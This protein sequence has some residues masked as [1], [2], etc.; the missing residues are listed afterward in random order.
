MNW[1]NPFQT[2]NTNQIGRIGI[3]HSATDVGS[4]RIFENHWRNVGWR[5]GGYH[6][7]I[8]LNGDVE[9]CYAPTV[10]TNG[11]GDHN[12]DSYHICVVG[13]FRISGNAPS[14]RQM[15]A[16][17]ERIRVNMNRFSIPIERVL[18]HNEFPNTSRFNH[19]SNICPGQNMN[20]LRNQLRLPT[21]GSTPNPSHP[22]HTARS[23]ETLSSIARLHGTT[24]VELQRLNNIQNPNLI[25]V[26][27][28]LKL[29]TQ[30]P[31]IQVGTPVRVNDGARNWATGETIPAWVRG[32]RYN[33]IQTR[34][35][36]QELLLNDVMS[37]INRNDVTPI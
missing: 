16:L 4:Q 34:R 25:R 12:A 23:G 29:P 1:N 6:E 31:N 13:N 24:V 3:H 22:V 2:R 32:R 17:I 5:N 21:V 30:H 27:Q 37:W 10:V 14:A 36:G 19:R 15:Q 11:V 8:L 33:V 20:N 28:I 9:I 26:G 18:G 35:D 7:I